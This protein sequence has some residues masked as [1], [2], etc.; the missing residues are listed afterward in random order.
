VLLHHPTLKALDRSPLFFNLTAL[1]VEYD[2][3]VPDPVR[4]NEFMGKLLGAAREEATGIPADAEAIAAL[5]EAIGC[6]VTGQLDQQKIFLFVG[7]ARGGKGTIAQVLKALLGAKNAA[8]PTLAHLGTH[9]GRESLIGKSL[10]VVSDVRREGGGEYTE[11]VVEVLL[12]IS[13]ADNQTIA[14]N[15]KSDWTSVD[16]LPLQIM[17]L[18]NLLLR[19]RDPSGVIVTRLIVIKL[20]ESWLGKEDTGL[21]DGLLTEL[22]G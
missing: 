12:A 8:W 9:F 18:S 6:I 5:E 17:I 19:F 11:A 14:R 13:G 2:P 21:L 4:W 7:P 10:A 16:R 22:P 20:T 1:Q 15:Y 3:A